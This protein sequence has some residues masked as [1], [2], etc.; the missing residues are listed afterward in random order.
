MSSTTFMFITFSA[1]IIYCFK[2]LF[3]VVIFG[4]SNFELI[5]QSDMKDDQNKLIEHDFRKF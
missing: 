5:K 4:N 1:E 3:E 2:M